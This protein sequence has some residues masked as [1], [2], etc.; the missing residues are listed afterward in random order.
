MESLFRKLGW[1]DGASDSDVADIDACA[2]SDLA[3]EHLADGQE[4][5][6]DQIYVHERAS[7]R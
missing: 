5:V 7:N 4:R 1:G 3:G 6:H 2:V